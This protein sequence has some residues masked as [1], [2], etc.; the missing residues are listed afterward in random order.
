MIHSEHD[1]GLNTTKGM[2]EMLSDILGD[3]EE[4]LPKSLNEAIYK[5]CDGTVF[6]V[7][8]ENLEPKSCSYY[9]AYCFK[10]PRPDV[11]YIS[12]TEWLNKTMELF[13]IQYR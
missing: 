12:Y 2:W 9:D 5:L 7:N 1:T 13:F 4:K 6:E 10:D 8:R 11:D 3:N